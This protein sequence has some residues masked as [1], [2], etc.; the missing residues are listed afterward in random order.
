[1][2]NTSVES[3]VM[4]GLQPDDMIFSKDVFDLES[5]LFREQLL[6]IQQHGWSFHILSFLKVKHYGH[7]VKYDILVFPRSF[8]VVSGKV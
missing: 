6:F 8:K 4:N 2:K 3:L 1:M 7:M 5:L